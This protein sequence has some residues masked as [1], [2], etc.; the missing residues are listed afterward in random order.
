[1]PSGDHDDSLSRLPTLQF[2]ND[3]LAYERR[4]LSLS[5]LRSK[6]SSFLAH[7]QL[8]SKECSKST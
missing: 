7:G 8:V 4:K 5:S 3:K 1:M 6:N 2:E